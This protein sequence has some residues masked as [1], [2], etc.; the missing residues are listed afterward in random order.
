MAF[1]RE[2]V[3]CANRAAV[4]AGAGLREDE[5]TDVVIGR[6]DRFRVKAVRLA[7]LFLLTLGASVAAVDTQ[8]VE[9]VEKWRQDFD[10]DIRTGGWLV[11]I[12]REK[13]GEGTWTLGSSPESRIVLPQP[14]PRHVG[15]L[16][17]RG[18]LF[19]LEP[20]QGV[21]LFI[22]DRAVKSRTVLSTQ[23]RA[24]K[25]KAGELS[26][27]VRRIADDFY[28]N[29]EDPNNPAIA[30]FKGS[31]WFMIDPSY[32]I[33]AKF[34]PYEKPREVMLPL[35]FESANKTFTST[36]DVVFQVAG[37]AMK[38]TTFILGDELFLI[39]Q[40]ETNG[41]ETYGGGR[42]LYA[43]LPENG[44]TTLDFNKAF[45]P[46]CA[47]N[48]YVLCPIVPAVNRL[49]IGIAAGAQFRK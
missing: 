23:Q 31:S 35:T 39:F 45:N 37:Q 30:E 28:L 1:A 2:D 18:E 19:E 16:I 9:Q 25:I 40:D 29:I 44:L 32:R 38:L 43:P 17:R 22:D 24:G 21:N 36:G 47:I 27:S 11:T 34:L 33:V 12:G 5:L 13:V 14:S 4:A 41:V 26:L 3:T 8:Y 48:S 20:T 42:F 49:P 15:T 6:H 46:Y 10:A 7:L